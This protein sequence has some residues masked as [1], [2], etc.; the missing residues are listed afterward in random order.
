[1]K[2]SFIPFLYLLDR[3]IV[4]RATYNDIKANPESKKISTVLGTKA[5]IYDI[6]FSV[7]VG[8]A[9][10]LVFLANSLEDS[11]ALFGVILLVVAA[12][13]VL[14][15]LSYFILGLNCSIKQ[16][17][18]NRRAIGWITL[19]L[20]LSILIAAIVVLVIIII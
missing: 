4:L 7:T 19:V 1:M 18:L 10:A 15:S 16:L 9:L 8:I 20:T 13:I 5:L 11:G 17:L 6:L 12:A 2:K 14:Y 3:F